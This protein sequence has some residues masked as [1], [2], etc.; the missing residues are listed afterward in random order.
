MAALPDLLTAIYIFRRHSAARFYA[1]DRR[2]KQAKEKAYDAAMGTDDKA[3]S[4]AETGNAGMHMGK[5]RR[6]AYGSLSDVG[7]SQTDLAGQA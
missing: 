2:T 3:S 4:C 1:P 6:N 7:C 5:H